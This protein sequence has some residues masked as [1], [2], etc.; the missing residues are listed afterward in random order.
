MSV[1]THKIWLVAVVFLLA[2]TSSYTQATLAESNTDAGPQPLVAETINQLVERLRQNSEEI[3][4]DQSIAYQISDELIVP[5]I[6]FPRI[7]RLIIG[8]YWRRASDDQRRALVEEVR[9]LLIR[10][11]VTAMTSY[12]DKIV[13]RS[14]H[15]RYQPSRYQPGDRKT[16]V[17][18]SIT[19]GD[20]QNV[21]VQY[22]LYKTSDQWKI[23]DIH[24]EGISL[25]ITYR[26]S[27]GEII[28]QD[29]L[30][31]LIAQLSKRNQKGDVELPN[32][33]AEPFDVQTPKLKA[34]N[35]NMA[36]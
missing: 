18:A 2:A 16:S 26:T 27:F 34:K 29:G 15:I 35:S 28:R 4:K 19:L 10:S 36:R 11:Y 31:S 14:K 20:G 1:Q 30:D 17:K 6:D 3:K 23:Y 12:A 5:R 25:A 9:S 24:I 21:A 33:V 7:T 22:Q 32:A 8:K 13:E